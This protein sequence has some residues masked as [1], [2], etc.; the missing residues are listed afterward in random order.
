MLDKFDT[1]QLTNED[2]TKL[3]DKLTRF[4]NWWFTHHDHSKTGYAAYYHI[5]ESGYDES[6]LFDKG[7]PLHAPDLQAYVVMLCEACSRL[8]TLIGKPER[9][10][11]WMSESTR[12]FTYLVDVLWD[13]EQFR[14]KLLTTGE[15]IKCGS[16]AQLQPAMLGRRLPKVIS[17]LCVHS[18][19]G[20]W[21]L[22]RNF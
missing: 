5:D 14:S 17:L 8:A 12:V 21:L 2:Y 19:E 15:H 9:A 18:P 6:T 4:T 16:I 10:A 20:P 13:G 7:L 1:S 3:Y 11:H 22:Q